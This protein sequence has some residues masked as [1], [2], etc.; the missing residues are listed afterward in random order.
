[1]WAVGTGSLAMTKLDWWAE[2]R[3]KEPPFTWQEKFLLVLMACESLGLVLIAGG[4][5][6]PF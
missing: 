4:A 5:L 3:G 6:R 2:L 1:M